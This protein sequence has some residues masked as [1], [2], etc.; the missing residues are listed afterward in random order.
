MLSKQSEK[1]LMR[2]VKYM[3]SL[4]PEAKEHFDMDSWFGH[5][6]GNHDYN[7][8]YGDPVTKR[9]LRYCGTSACA[10]GYAATIPAFRRRGLTMQ[11]GG[12]PRYGNDFSFDAAVS[13]FNISHWQSE[14]LFS[15]V[16]TVRTPKQW[17]KRAR[18]LIAK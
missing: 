15:G 10:L 14:L 13:F 4:P 9:T 5:R 11:V 3:E 7:L 6:R 12:E 1:D 2:L 16:N 8:A 18:R 17:A